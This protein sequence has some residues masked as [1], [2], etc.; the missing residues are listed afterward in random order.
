MPQP[1]APRNDRRWN[2]MNTRSTGDFIF[3]KTLRLQVRLASQKYF[4]KKSKNSLTAEK[5]HIRFSIPTA[6]MVTRSG[7]FFA[8]L[9]RVHEQV[10][11]GAESPLQAFESSKVTWADTPLSSHWNTIFDSADPVLHRHENRMDHLD[12]NNNQQKLNCAFFVN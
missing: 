12:S 9:P 4:S 5:I 3:A 10:R 6:T 7:M 8:S 2:L 11:G 1:L